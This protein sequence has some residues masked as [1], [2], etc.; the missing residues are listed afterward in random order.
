MS[1]G[2]EKANCKNNYLASSPV[3]PYDA[4]GN[5]HK[6]NIA[7]K[8]VFPSRIEIYETTNSLTVIHNQPHQCSVHSEQ[9]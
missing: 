4:N 5:V 2:Y 1:I 6:C 7:P 3:V 9:S 8:L